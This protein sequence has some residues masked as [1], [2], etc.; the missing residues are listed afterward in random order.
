MEPTLVT[1]FEP[2]KVSLEAARKICRGISNPEHGSFF[3]QLVVRFLEQFQPS[4]DKLSVDVKT[5]PKGAVNF[6]ISNATNPVVGMPSLTFQP[7]D[8]IKLLD[9]Q[10]ELLAG[11]RVNIAIKYECRIER[12]RSR[13]HRRRASP[14]P[15]SS[16]S[17]SPRPRRHK[18]Q[19]SS[20]PSP[21]RRS[22]SPIRRPR[23]P[24]PPP[25]RRSPS[26]GKKTGWSLFG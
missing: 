22:P 12:P 5:G 14:S 13:S 26:T 21:S 8:G 9:Q 7:P 6:L 17:P 18:R 11:D 19:S 15:S 20:S 2:Q 1:Q 25:R 3:E 24:S 4:N 10:T 23:S 16:R